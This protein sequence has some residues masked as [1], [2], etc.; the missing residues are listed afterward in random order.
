VRI[1]EEKFSDHS[2]KSEKNP[3]KNFEKFFSMIQKVLL[4]V[5]LPHNW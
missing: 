5:E 4:K 3:A 2:G 1:S